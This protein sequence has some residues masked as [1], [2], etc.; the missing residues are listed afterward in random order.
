MD[1]LHAAKRR[2]ILRAAHARGGKI[3]FTGWALGGHFLRSARMVN[4]ALRNACSS[5]KL[6]P[7]LT[8]CQFSMQLINSVRKKTLN[9]LNLLTESSDF[10]CGESQDA[11]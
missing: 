6:S 8:P 5:S 11:V 9:S 1:G 3:E 10:G 7:P 2:G 4:S